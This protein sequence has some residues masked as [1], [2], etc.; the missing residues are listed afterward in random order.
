MTRL[1]AVLLLLAG[2]GLPPLLGSNPIITTAY[3]ADPSGHI[4]NGRLYVYPS[5]DRND[6]QGYNMND[7]HCYSTDDLQNWR[8]EGIIL[9]LADVPWAREQFWAPDCNVKDGTYYFYFP[10]QAKDG[11]GFRVGM[12]SG[13]SPVGPFQDSGGPIPGVHGID[14]SI[15]MDDDGTPYLIWAGTGL[16]VAKLKPNMKELDGPPVTVAGI[17]NFFE[18]P[19]LFKR[20]GT[21]YMTYPA[22]MKG[23]SNQ[24]GNGQFFDYATSQNVMGPYEYQGHFTGTGDPYA[25]NIHGSQFEWLGKWYCLYH[26]FWISYGRTWHGCKRAMCLDEMTFSA[27]GKI[28]PLIWTKTG[29]PQLKPLDPYKKQPANCLN[30]TDIPEGPLAVRTEPCSLGGIDV[31]GL[32][33]GAW[34]QYAGVNFGPAPGAK[35]FQAQVASPLSGCQIELHLDSLDGPIIGTCDLPNT[36]G[37]QTWKTASCPISNASG[38]H[39]LVMKFK[40][41]GAQGQ[42]AMNAYQFFH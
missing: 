8:D 31:G 5:H 3:T 12:A 18:G 22:Y 19:W 41:G 33:E 34:I 20:N 27:D 40:G 35:T 42:L 14:P 17:K 7:Y 23:G 1:M 26:T 25:I 9:K 15:Y 38:L 13:P 10:A 24:G 28:N 2:S 39:N 37:L 36:G 11:S 32:K 29:P 30:Q 21:Y 6:A 4:F 16:Q